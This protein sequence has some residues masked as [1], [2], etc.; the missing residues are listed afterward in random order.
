M[1]IYQNLSSKTGY[2]INLPVKFV[3]D[4]SVIV[5]WFFEEVDSDRALEVFDLLHSGQVSGLAPDIIVYEVA[6]ALWK[7]KK[8]PRQRILEALDNLQASGLR[9]IRLNSGV[10]EAAVRIMT[11]HDLSFYDA[12]YAGL[13]SM[14]DIPLMTANIK[15]HGKVKEIEIL[16]L[17]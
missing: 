2:H 6:N 4:A 17:K 15:H 1:S 13:A 7:G 5:K 3:L 10:A 16:K 14:L 9:I 11:L 8:A 12:V